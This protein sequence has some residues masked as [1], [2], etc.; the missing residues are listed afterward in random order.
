MVLGCLVCDGVHRFCNRCRISQVI[1]TDRL[2][3]LIQ[4]VHEGD[5]GGDIQIYDI[6]VGNA[7]EVLH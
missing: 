6:G 2:E 1:M 4:F 7:I 3:L 5:S